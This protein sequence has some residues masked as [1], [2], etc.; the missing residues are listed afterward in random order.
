MFKTQQ[1]DPPQ[2]LNWNLGPRNSV[3]ASEAKFN[4]FTHVSR[5]N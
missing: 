3:L 5:E 2:E 1:L 4:K